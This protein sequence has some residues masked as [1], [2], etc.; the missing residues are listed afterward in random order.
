VGIALE[1]CNFQGLLNPV[2]QMNIADDLYYYD[3][4][5]M[6]IQETHIKEN[7]LHEIKSLSGERANS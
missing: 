7:G 1:I 2:K 4:T 6:M 3:L 5:A